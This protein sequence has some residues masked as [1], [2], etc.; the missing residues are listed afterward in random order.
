MATY[1]NILNLDKLDVFIEEEG[2]STFFNIS[3]LPDTIG[4]GKHYF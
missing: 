3:D 4:Y 2:N 1:T